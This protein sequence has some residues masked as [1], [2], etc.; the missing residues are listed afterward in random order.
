MHVTWL[1]SQRTKSSL[2]DLD[3]TW[4]S[5]STFSTTLYGQYMLHPGYVEECENHNEK[6][7][8]NH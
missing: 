8:C 6:F 7:G 1:P 4:D 2:L 3:V 5:K